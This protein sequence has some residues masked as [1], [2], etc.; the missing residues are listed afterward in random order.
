VQ[1][2]NRH[3]SIDVLPW[4]THGLLESVGLNAEQCSA[5]AWFVDASG[6]QQRGAAAI[7]AALGAIGGVWRIVPLLYRL[8]G[9][10]HVANMAY[11]W[12]AANRYRLPGSS[13]ACA[14]P[15]QKD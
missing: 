2:L 1:R 8:P 15:Q 14:V 5:A 7:T 13:A 11:A 9:I 4:Q 10:R 12:V 6:A 3:Q